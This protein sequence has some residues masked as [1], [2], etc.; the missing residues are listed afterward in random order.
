MICS[1]FQPG[2]LRGTRRETSAMSSRKQPARALV[3]PGDPVGDLEASGR[4]CT[5]DEVPSVHGYFRTSWV[6]LPQSHGLLTEGSLQRLLNTHAPFFC[7]LCFVL[8]CF[9]MQFC[10]SFCFWLKKTC[11]DIH[12]ALP[13]YVFHIHTRGS[14]MI[15][16]Y[17]QHRA[18]L[19]L[20]RGW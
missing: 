18:D 10:S 20:D 12:R 8:A 5:G 15:F 11:W 2:R 4:A 6:R 13:T 14:D 9:Q 19:V 16:Q 17:F 1:C 3:G 7:S